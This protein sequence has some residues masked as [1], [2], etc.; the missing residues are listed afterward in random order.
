MFY[1]EKEKKK[2]DVKGMALDNILED[3]QKKLAGDFISK[4]KKPVA[5]KV[6]IAVAK[7]PMG[8]NAKP[9]VEIESPEEAK[10]E[11]INPSMEQMEEMPEG[12]EEFTNQ[13]GE[14]KGFVLIASDGSE[15]EIDEDIFKELKDLMDQ[16]E[17]P[18]VMI[19]GKKLGVKSLKG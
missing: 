2:K 7:K 9:M 12:H 17:E 14:G 19:E 4:N 6:E 8:M 5:A 16:G 1:K 15:H 10:A 13:P 11:E 3:V 18:E